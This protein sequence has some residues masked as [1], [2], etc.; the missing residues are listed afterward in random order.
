MRKVFIVED[1][2]EMT[3]CIALAIQQIKNVETEIFGDVIA[4][5]QAF[6]RQLPQL[7]FLDILLDGPDGF[8]LLNELNS[9]S[10]TAK[11]PIIIATSLNLPELNQLAYNVAAILDKETMTPEQIADSV[12]SAL[13]LKQTLSKRD[14]G[15][16]EQGDDIDAC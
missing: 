13:V 1:D 16:L 15:E 5:V 8:T 6:D 2:R 12:C 4:A 7:I 10:D 11:I 3:E 9:Y 14:L